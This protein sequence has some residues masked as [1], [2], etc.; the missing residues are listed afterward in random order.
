M[1]YKAETELSKVLRC[2][3]VSDALD[4]EVTELPKSVT[5]NWFVTLSLFS[6]KTN[7]VKIRS[8]FL[9][10]FIYLFI[11]IYLIIKANGPESVQ[12]KFTKRLPEYYSLDY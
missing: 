3:H 9:P 6:G 5:A 4:T 1:T 7:V 2:Y 12:R 10:L 8:P 11:Y